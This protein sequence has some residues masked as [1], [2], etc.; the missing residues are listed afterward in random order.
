MKR[1]NRPRGA[2]PIREDSAVAAQHHKH[3]LLVAALS[4]CVA[5][6]ASLAPGGKV[7]ANRQAPSEAETA[8]GADSTED[9]VDRIIAATDDTPTENT[10]TPE[11]TAPPVAESAVTSAPADGWI[12]QTV[13]PGDNL[14]LIFNRAGFDN[15]DVHELVYGTEQGKQLARSYP[16]QTIAFRTSDAGELLGVRH[17]LSPLET[18]TYLRDS[19]GQYLTERVV[20]EPEV[21]EAR[22]SG[23]ITSSL[24]IAGQ[25]MGL[26][27]HQDYRT[28]QHLWRR[29]R[30]RPRPAQG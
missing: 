20:R 29:H 14:S 6:A 8:A 21:R 2:T 5:I 17:V 25:D 30:L 28:G 19:E 7:E 12:A 15:G 3:L 22:S 16:G 18:I 10:S 27:P 1:N 9:T 26:S 24:F 4:V 13:R 11:P 23:E